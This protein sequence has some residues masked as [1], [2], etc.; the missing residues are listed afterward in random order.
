[1]NRVCSPARH[2]TAAAHDADEEDLDTI[3]AQMQMPEQESSEAES[4]SFSDALDN[5]LASLLEQLDEDSEDN[6]DGDWMAEI[7]TGSLELGAKDEPL[8]YVDDFDREWVKD[9]GDEQSGGAPWLS[10]AMRET[11]DK[12]E[13]VDFDLFG[14]D[15][16]LQTLLNRTSDTEPI[17]LSDIED[18]LDTG[19]EQESSEGEERYVELEDDLL[20]SPP[21]RSWLEDEPGLAD[22]DDPNRANAD[23]IESWQ[24]E[25]GADDE[26][27]D[28]Y[29]DWLRDDPNELA[30]GDLEMFAAESR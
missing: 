6:A 13:A 18:W 10:A 9:S 25:L 11:L 1:M 14:E 29:V 26:D 16:Q 15:E 23:L 7:Q 20:H 21:A 8:D 12:D 5:E 4:D 22:E 19:S 17:H 28:P 2:T 24:S 3:L 27:D 30:D